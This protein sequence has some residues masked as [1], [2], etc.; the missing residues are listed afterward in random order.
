MTSDGGVAGWGRSGGRAAAS[1]GGDGSEGG[2]SGMPSLSRSV[3][4]GRVGN[5]YGQ[6]EAVA[7]KE[8]GGSA[9]R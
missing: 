8:E 3:T 9:D 7:G 4:L 2:S 6:W 5:D 1:M